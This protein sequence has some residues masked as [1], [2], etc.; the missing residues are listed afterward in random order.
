MKRPALRLWGRRMARHQLPEGAAAKAAPG[1]PWL[2]PVRRAVQ[3]A[4]LAL[5]APMGW[6][7]IQALAGSPP[8]EQI[9]QH[10]G[11]YAYLLLSTA[12]VLSAVGAVIG[13]AEESLELANEFL[14]ELSYTDA[15][16]GLKN[17]R[18]LEARLAEALA[19]S[20]RGGGAVALAILDLDAFNTVNDRFG[21]PTGRQAAGLGRRR[22]PRRLPPWRYGRPPGGRGVRHPSS[23]L[24]RAGGSG[25]CG[26]SPASRGGNQATRAI[27]RGHRDNLGRR[28]QHRG[29][30]PPLPRRPLRPGRQSAVRGQETRGNCVLLAS[31][32]TTHLGPL[33]EGHW[34]AVPRRMPVSRHGSGSR[35]R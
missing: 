31:A 18:Y 8:T 29:A 35:K 14:T 33:A 20:Q 5:G 12:V 27:R 4:F 21:H 19:G 15:G 17:R 16:T 30:R 13:R 1:R 26:A 2:R 10:P 23:R 32:L 11:L 9:S 24:H 28:G 6:L 3:R 34:S 25:R 22:P 7:L